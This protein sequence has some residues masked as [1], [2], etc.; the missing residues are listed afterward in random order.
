MLREISVLD[1]CQH[2]NVMLMV[3]FFNAKKDIFVVFGRCY[4]DAEWVHNHHEDGIPI[5][6]ATPPLPHA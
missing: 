3:E 4:G 5:E 6:Q 1:A 2:A